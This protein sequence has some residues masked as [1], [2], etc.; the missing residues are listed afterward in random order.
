MRTLFLAV[1]GAVVGLTAC[2]SGGTSTLPVERTAVASVVVALPSSSL[3]VGQ[4]ARGTATARDAS[5]NSLP[6]RAITWQTSSTAIASVD[7]TGMISAVAP[8]TAEI[9]AASEGVTGQA[10]LTVAAPSPAPVASVSVALVSSSLNIGQTTQANATT[11]DA[12]NNV[13]AG[14]VISWASSNTNVATVSGLGLVSAVAAGTAQITATSEGQSGS[15]ALAVVSPPPP[16]APVASVT[17]TLAASSRAPGQ[18]TQATAVTRDA[19]NNVLTGRVITWSSGNL[20][21]ATVSGSG[22]VTALVAGTAQITATSEG[23]SGSAT[24]TV[25]APPPPAPVASVTVTL[26][27]STRN[28]GQT[29]QAT[30][31]TLDAN[32]NVLTGRVITWVSGTPAVAT[33]SSTGLVTAVAV[34]T[35]QISATSE[36][37]TGSAT[38]T[39]QDP[40]PP[41][42][43][44]SSNEPSGMTV[45]SDRPFN[46]LNELG[47]DDQFSSNMAFIADATAPKSPSGILRA[48]W[49]TGYTSIGNGPG[50][51][52]MPISSKR[53]VYISF[54]AKLSDNFYGH[55]SN[56]N[57]QFYAYAN[58]WPVMYFDASCHASG[59]ITP[60]IALQDTQSHGTYDLTPNLV[61]SARIPRGQWYRIEVVLVGNTAGTNDGSVD[62]WL[63]GV[64][65]GSYTVQWRSGAATWDLFHYT[66]IWGGSGGYTVPATMTMDW[67]HVYLSGKN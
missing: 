52:D 20:T 9:I 27:A 21:V 36:G 25:T 46:A 54:W 2:S 31:V 59:P 50:G 51:S 28:P 26:A 37:Q 49:P 8:G 15:A 11:R 38:L 34:G 1:T 19:N 44:G 13:L 35:A 22:L 3:L 41:P 64:H 66:T 43:P 61:P 53:T 7:N 4:T 10:D 6:D 42:P 45:I 48:T 14:R 60:Q 56:V 39:V 12:N 30:A 57:K 5:G 16:P 23:Q 47:W 55:D 29:T 65:V 18:T 40:P 58:Q 24:F 17:V 62:W 67:D 63:D 32:N 33:V